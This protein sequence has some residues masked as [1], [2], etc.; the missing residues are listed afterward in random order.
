MACDWPKELIVMSGRREARCAYC[1][2]V[3][4]RGHM[5]R[6]HVF[7]TAWYPETTPPTVQRWTVPSCVACNNQKSQL[8]AYCLAQLS[9][10]VDVESTAAR[11]IWE[12][13]FRSMRIQD[14]GSDANE[15]EHRN[16]ALQS[17]MRELVP[18]DQVR[19]SV[20]FPAPRT[21]ASGLNLDWARVERLMELFARGCHC[22]IE[23]RPLPTDAMVNCYRRAA[24]QPIPDLV[25]QLLSQARE[26]ELPRKSVFIARRNR[27]YHFRFALKIML[28]R[29]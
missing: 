11:G 29:R 5:T 3:L 23:Q 26:Y 7:P 28:L 12:R 22:Y 17:V 14:A 20:S 15:R 19:P 10:G 27:T 25:L 24:W 2:L 13:A 1:A 6:D 18:A 16:R 8:E 9:A 21:G 4:Q